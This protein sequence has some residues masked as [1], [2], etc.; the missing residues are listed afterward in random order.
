MLPESRKLPQNNAAVASYCHHAHKLREPAKNNH[1]GESTFPSVIGGE[2]N[3]Q[4]RGPDMG[5]TCT[6]RSALWA[7]YSLPSEA[8]RQRQE[9]MPS[10]KL[11]ITMYVTPK[12]HAHISASA[13]R[14]NR[15]L[16]N[17]CK[18]VSMGY[19]VPGLE[20]VKLRLE[21]R[22]LR[23][24]LGKLGGLVKLALSEGADR[25]TVHKLLHELDKRQ[26]E[27]QEAVN[28]VE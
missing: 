16:S 11:R 13:D 7:A 25:H 24:D 2:L 5:S 27:V 14:T 28:S 3:N 21:L 1:N 20:H 19:N 17:F 4:K 6:S 22:R 12:E 26:K 9:K 15:S 23:G 18:L 10:K 8:Q